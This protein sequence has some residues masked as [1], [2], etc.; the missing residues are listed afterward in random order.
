MDNSK[1]TE[2]FALSKKNYKLLGIAIAI[3][4]VGYLLMAGG[5]SPSPDVFN[6]EMFS[7]RRITLAPL[8]LL[9]GYFFAIYAIMVKD[10]SAK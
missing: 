10:K 4:V 8:V 3:I 6:E 5:R 9:F 1:Q 2:K 7:F